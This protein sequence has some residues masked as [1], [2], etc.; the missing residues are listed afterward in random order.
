V[1]IRLN[2]RLVPNRV[3]LAQTPMLKGVTNAVEENSC[4]INSDY[5]KS[6][7]NSKK[8]TFVPTNNSNDFSECL[9]GEITVADCFNLFSNQP[10]I[11]VTDIQSIIINK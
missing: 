9:N 11:V 1:Y 4:Q 6:G 5:K 8:L 3:F 2:P 7:K 10:V